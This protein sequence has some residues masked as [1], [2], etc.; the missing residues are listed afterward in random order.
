MGRGNS[1]PAFPLMDRRDALVTM[2]DGEIQLQHLLKAANRNVS[3]SVTSHLDSKTLPSSGF[4]K[5]AVLL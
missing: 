3:F 4:T 5:L 1:G 2:D